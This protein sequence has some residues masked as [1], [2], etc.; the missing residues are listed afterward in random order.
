MENL[1]AIFVG[2]IAFSLAALPVGAAEMRASMVGE[3]SIAANHDDC[4]AETEPCEKHTKNECDQSGACAVKCSVVPATTVAG[5]DLVLPALT[6][7]KEAPAIA[8]LS[9]ALEHPPLPPPRV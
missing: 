8:N 4:C 2:L 6:S 1:R 3:V 5:M 7:E 9:S